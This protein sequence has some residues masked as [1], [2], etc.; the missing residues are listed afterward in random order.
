M[1]I[2]RWRVK[3]NGGDAQ[4]S[5]WKRFWVA[6]V[7]CVSM[8]LVPAHAPSPELDALKVTRMF[9][10]YTDEN[11]TMG[12]CN[13]TGCHRPLCSQHRRM[14]MG[15]VAADYQLLE[16]MWHHPRR[17]LDPGEAKLFVVPTLIAVMSSFLCDQTFS[18]TKHLRRAD[19]AIVALSTNRWFARH[20]GQ[21]HLI[22][23]H[24]YEY[25]AWTNYGLITNWG[26]LQH[27]TATRYEVYGLS[28]YNSANQTAQSRL[29]LGP[30]CGLGCASTYLNSV[31]ERT[32]RS[33]VTPYAT[34]SSLPVV[35][36]V[37]T[38]FM[39]R[40]FLIWYHSRSS[41]SGNGGGP[42][43]HLPFVL[44]KYFIL[45]TMDGQAPARLPPDWCANHC[46]TAVQCANN[47]SVLAPNSKAS[48]N[49]SWNVNI[50]NDKSHP[51]W[52][53]DSPVGFD[54]PQDKWLAGWSQSKFCLVIRGDTPSTHAFYSAIRSGCIP[55]V[56]SDMLQY[57]GLPFM[58]TKLDDFAGSIS[59]ADFYSHPERVAPMLAAMD[60][61]VIAAK[62]KA[63]Q[64]AQRELVY[65]A[66]NPAVVD[67]VLTV[68]SG[69]MSGGLPTNNSAC[70]QLQHVPVEKVWPSSSKAVR[71][72]FGV[73]VGFGD[74]GFPALASGFYMGVTLTVVFTMACVWSQILTLS[75]TRPG[76]VACVC[77]GRS[78]VAHS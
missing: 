7:T 31:W 35:H 25:S 3:T 48:W 70:M 18:K 22:L 61:S 1:P 71:V 29:R 40:R 17:T 13:L 73:G 55:V 15:K 46:A 62:L 43:R 47:C 8:C 57:V 16:S 45:A 69:I 52:D 5:L 54:V 50:V 37:L 19:A 6:V 32:E 77:R 44:L 64:S 74:V 63:L 24:G 33:I 76:C 28:V 56:I 20:C 68:L 14:F 67:N 75:R 60:Q 4:R 2:I 12:L 36:P 34:S 23:T 9:Y 39:G 65:T 26:Q 59:E 58:T 30:H 72:L 21:D 27:T 66:Q 49:A 78:T 10:I 53:P 51:L 11:V 38:D 41:P 42:I